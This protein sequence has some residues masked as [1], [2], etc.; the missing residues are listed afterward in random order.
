MLQHIVEGLTKCGQHLR[1]HGHL[2]QRPHP[3][4]GSGGR[5]G[6]RRLTARRKTGNALEK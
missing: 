5:T 1:K 2:Q 4:A 3:A 6:S